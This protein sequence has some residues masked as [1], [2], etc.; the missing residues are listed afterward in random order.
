M[1]GTYFDSLLGA[2][3][4]QGPTMYVLSR[5]HHHPDWSADRILDEYYAAFGPAEPGVR[6]YFGYWERHARALDPEDVSRYGQEESGGSFKDYVRIAHRLFTPEDFARARA[7]L[8]EAR[9]QAEG[10]AR[11]LRRVAFLDQ[12]LTD[13]ELTTATRAAQARLEAEETE[14]H[15]AAFEAAFNRLVEHRTMMEASGDH[16]ANL[17]Y[18]AFR[19]YHGSGWP[20]LRQPDQAELAREAS[21]AARWPELTVRDPSAAGLRLASRHPLPR[22]GWR[23]HVDPERTGDLRGWHQ[24]NLNTEGWQEAEIETAWEA[25]LGEPYIGAGWYR[26]TIEAPELPEGGAAYLQF[27]GVDESCWV[28]VNGHYVGSHDVGPQGWDAPF[29]LEI[30]PA[31]RPGENVVVVRAMNTA[32]AGGVWR[33]VHLAVHEPAA[34]NE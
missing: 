2:W 29:E 22:T 11:T 21:F 8:E 31:L 12:G 6:A 24:A 7:L 16:A 18:F 4:A 17:G 3:S 5:I 30:T 10:D 9:R 34:G 15:R 28:W 32:F 14:E 23:F 19:E 26:R 1:I 27:G 33:P 20:H 25:F 13:A